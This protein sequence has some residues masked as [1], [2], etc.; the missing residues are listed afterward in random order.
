MLKSAIPN[1][2]LYSAGIEYPAAAIAGRVKRVE[3]QRST[4]EKLVLKSAIVKFAATSDA[5]EYPA[6]AIAG[7]AKRVELQRSTIV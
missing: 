2:A 6:A 7:R 4:I 5:M 3:L 1:W